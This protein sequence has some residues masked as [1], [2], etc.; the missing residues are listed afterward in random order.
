MKKIRK[1]SNDYRVAH[2]APGPQ[3]SPAYNLEEYY[4]NIYS[5]NGIRYYGGFFEDKED[6]KVF[7]LFHKIKDKPNSI[8]TIY[9]SVPS[10]VNTI[11]IGDWVTVNKKYAETHAWSEDDWKILSLKVKAKD[12]FNNGDSIYEFGYYPKE[13]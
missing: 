1:N 13:D 2:K 9:R 6:L 5:K 11:N 7:A 4:P 12:I 10:E 8:V 3:Y